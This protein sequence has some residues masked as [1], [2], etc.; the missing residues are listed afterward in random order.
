MSQR[1]KAVYRRGAFLPKEPCEVPEGSEV[2]LTIEGPFLL[3]PE[4]REPKEQKH[5]LKAI[6]ERMRQNPIPAGAPPLTRESLHER[7]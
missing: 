1:L 3:S 7:P 5:I 6:V 4:V 2:E